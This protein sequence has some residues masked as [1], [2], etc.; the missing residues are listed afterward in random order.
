MYFAG[1]RVGGASLKKMGSPRVLVVGPLPPPVGGVETVTKAVLESTALKRF[2][3]SHCDLTKCR[4]K[5][6]QGKFDLSN[7]WWA[8]IHFGR[9]RRSMRSFR[10]EVVYM[11][12]STTWSGFWRDSVLAYIAK[13]LGAR[14]AGHIHGPKLAEVLAKRGFAGRLVKKCIDQFDALFVLDPLWRK[15]LISHGYEKDVRVIPST[16]GKEVFDIGMTFTR[17]FTKGNAIG[18]FVGQVGK[19]KGVFDLLDALHQLKLAA[20]PAR[21]RIVGAPEY[22][23]EWDA[24]MKRRDELQLSDVAEF[25]GALRG[26]ALYHEFRQASYFVLPSYREGLPVV[27]FEAGAF[28]LPVVTTPVGG[29]PQLLKHESNAL[30]VSPG[31]IAEI[32]AAIHRLAS[33]REDRERF[34]LRLRNDV[35]KYHPEVVCDQIADAIEALVCDR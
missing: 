30:L 27:L 17:D 11:P 13:R 34:G 19:R 2:K 31:D 26:E 10:P 14:V 16:L 23:G 5:E 29:I 9:M 15:W 4:P 28:G 32:A 6:T 8:M 3:T 35:S 12:F 21:V 18:L 24:L 1:F 25:T 7:F 22:E 20:M 33:S